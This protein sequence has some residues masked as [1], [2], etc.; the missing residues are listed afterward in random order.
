MTDVELTLAGKRNWG[1]ALGD[2]RASLKALPSGVV[3]CVV[4]SGW[5]G[6]NFDNALC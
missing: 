4:T 3:H 2:V 1:V 5:V 6:A